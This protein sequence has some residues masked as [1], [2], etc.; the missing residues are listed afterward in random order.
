MARVDTFLDAMRPLLEEQGAHGAWLFGSQA[1]GTAAPES[2]IDIIV[3]QPSD[4]PF[5]TRGLA[6]MP[7]I[8]EAGGAVDILVY[9]PEEFEAMKAEERPFL[10]DA[11]EDAKQVYVGRAN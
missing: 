7:A 9:T 3:V 4:E 5:P 6:Y 10:V 11:L 1:T 8:L 2:D